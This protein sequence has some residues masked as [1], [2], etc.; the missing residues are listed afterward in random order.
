[1]RK[2]LFIF[3]SI[4]FNSVLLSQNTPS[5]YGR[6]T[7]K[8]TNEALAGATVA[9][10]GTSVSGITNNEGRFLLRNLN[11]GNILITISFVGYETI[12]VPATVTIT[13]TAIADAALVVDSR[14]GN[15]VVI[16]AS[17]RAE[18]IVN[19]PA[20]I[21]VIGKK[22]LEQ[23]TGS[24]TF[25]L[26]SKVQGVETVRIGVDGINVN[27]RGLN[28]AFNNKVF[29]MIDGRNS[30]S[31][32]STSL[33]LGNNSS[34]NKDDIERM[35]ILLGPQ[36]ALYGPNVHN[37]LVNVITKDP[38]K[39]PGTT[40]ALSA[41]NQNQFSGRFRHAIKI[42]NKWA[43]KL[44]G[45][46]MAG[47]NF[48]FYDSVKVGGGPFGVFG[49]RTTIPEKIDHDFRRYRG[50]AHI[51]YSVTPKADIIITTGGSKYDYTMIQT[52]G[53][54]QIKGMENV[55]LQGRYVSP[56]FFANIYNAWANSGFALSVGGYTRDLWNRT[57]SRSTDP[58]DPNHRLPI[59][60]AEMFATRRSNRLIE[61]N[62]RLNAEVQYNYNFEKARLFLVTGLS[63]QN[64]RPRAYGNTLVDSFERIIVKQY[65]V[66]LQLEKSLPWKM[67]LISAAR[68]DRHSG[69]GNYFSP[70]LGLVKS[71]DKGNFRITWG[72]A[73]SMP[74]I[75]WQY[76]SNG[77]SFFGNREGITYIPNG[78]KLSDEVTKVTTP[79]KPE[80]VSTWEFGYKGSLTKKLYV[81][82]S[83]YSG[84][85]KHFFTPSISVGGRAIYVG[86]RRV[87]HDPDVAGVPDA[88]D[89]LR[90]A[91]FG[92][93]FNF[94][95]VRVYGFDVGV[96]YTFNKFVNLSVKYSWI[97]SDITKG[98]I[99][100]DANKDGYVAA[101]ERSLNSPSNR[102]IAILN[103]Q[104][105]CKQ[106]MF[107]DLSA[108]YISQYD[109]Y[110][111]GQVSTN[112]GE[113]R[114]DTIYAYP[115]G[116]PAIKYPK[117]FNWGPLGGFATIDLG[118][119]Y[120]FNPMLSI[121]MNITNLFNTKQREF[122]GSPLIETLIMFELKMQ[123]PSVNNKQ[124][125][126]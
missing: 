49:P 83:C 54:N 14:M 80:R 107:V 56:H 24:N 9:I 59:D 110:S 39:Y 58:N 12:E 7:D 112:M 79:L 50:E 15:E 99:A 74:S 120:K 126:Q 63:Y 40:V 84:L 85:S 117:N 102:L 47:T 105:L 36:T 86:S 62:Q 71:I 37:V 11:T 32:I 45:E 53:H 77:G 23:F 57:Q 20:S 1:M 91:R 78:T 18:K 119:G 3:L 2:L 69:Y 95:D 64:D 42:N 44:T 26:L 52:G 66:V 19:A 116:N 46:Y 101:D 90:N 55:F 123:I 67:R 109:F 16:S 51:Y 106:K 98:N 76:A 70:K 4:V 81:D 75:S 104:N 93:I 114:L 115:P 103:F 33:L 10:K 118:A 113:G 92:T 87:T 22:E 34:A 8:L 31:A 48:E 100:N 111:G 88:K 121:G 82:I 96:T 41:G 13:N 73:Y 29:H 124:Q 38:R 30:M 17:R 21:Q 60:S 5:I 61:N 35:E 68:W 108:R 97:A 25:E 122:A 6:V 94:G 27:A 43:Y 72:Q 89:T 65:G 125:N 28:N